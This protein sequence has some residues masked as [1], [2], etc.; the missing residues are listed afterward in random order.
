MNGST[1]SPKRTSIAFLAI[2]GTPR[3][4]NWK[5]I[6]VKRVRADEKQEFQPS[7]FP[8]LGSHALVMREKAINARQPILE[9][10]TELL[11]W[12]PAMG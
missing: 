9:Q 6:R 2:D 3:G 8:W 5:P 1:R 12:R 11:P 4:A 7:D 10:C